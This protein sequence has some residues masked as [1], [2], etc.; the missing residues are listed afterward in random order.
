ME[1]A[2]QEGRAGEDFDEER[3]ASRLLR[4]VWHVTVCPCGFA[5]STDTT[6]RPPPRVATLFFSDSTCLVFSTQTLENLAADLLPIESE[7]NATQTMK[8]IL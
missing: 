5:H 6:A 3:G 2:C 8:L 4:A 7:A 1:D